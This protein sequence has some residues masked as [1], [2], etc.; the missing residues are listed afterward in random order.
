LLRIVGSCGQRL[1]GLEP[2]E[3]LRRQKGEAEN[4]VLVAHAATV[5]SEPAVSWLVDNPGVV[6]TTPSGLPAAIACE[7]GDCDRAVQ[8]IDGAPGAESLNPALIEPMFIRKLRRRDTL[9]VRRLDES[10]VASVERE[11]FGTVY[12]GV[13]DIVTK[14][15]WPVPAYWATK[16]CARLGIGPN[17]VTIVGIALVALVAW[18]WSNGQ[19]AEGLALAWFMTF[20][21]TVDGKLA[22]V[23]VTS[24]WLGNILDHATDI[25]HPPIWWICLAVG[26]EGRFPDYSRSIWA[27]CWAILGAYAL[28][29]AIEELFKRRTGY[30][31]YLWRP[32]DSAFRLI[33]SRRN[34]I[35]LILS[36]GAISGTLVVA[37]LTTAAWTLVSVAV[38]LVRFVQAVAAGRRGKVDTW[39]S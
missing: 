35:L 8:W 30:N 29:R 18:L 15:A 38:Q 16:F 23:T 26:L 10:P 12:K 36:F 27:A 24:S 4:P 25:I 34:I 22:R 13:T 5:L 19:I 14:Y 28:G 20:L 11:L 31:A 6:L 37:F 39:L 33:V 17:L 2:A 3:R 32:F 9:L 1:F 7:P 21:D